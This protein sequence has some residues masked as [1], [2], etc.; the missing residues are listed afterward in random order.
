MHAPSDFQLAVWTAEHTQLLDEI[1]RER[2]ALGEGT[3][4][5]DQNRFRVRRSSGLVIAGKPDLT[6]IDQMGNCT[7]YDAKTGNPK[8]SDIIQVMLYMMFL[9]YASPL[10]KGKNFTGC[11][12][13]K[14]G[15]RSNI[16]ASAIDKAFQKNITYFLNIL[17]SMN[18]P[19][20]IP[21]SPE[22]QYCDITG[23]DCPDRIEAGGEYLSPGD[24]PEIPV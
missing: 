13:Y 23:A 17:D 19:E 6:T 11:V 22:C 5:E 14:T 16:P 20:R 9:P 4:R 7:V 18:P 15:N 2:S 21:S 1:C 3:Y 12:V 8:Q 10:Y 24:E